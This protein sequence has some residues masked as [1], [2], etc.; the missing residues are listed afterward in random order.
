[1]LKAIRFIVNPFQEN[2]YVL[3]DEKT[4]E[5]AI[6]DPGCYD[7]EEI[8]NLKG[9]IEENKLKPKKILLTHGHFD[10]ICGVQ[11]IT[12]AYG[13]PIYA[14]SEATIMIA[15]SPIHALAFGITIPSP[16]KIDVDIHDGDEVI[17]GNS[18]LLVGHLPGHSRGSVYFYAK[19]NKFVV[20][21]DILFK[22]SIG[23]TDL[24]GGDLQYL[25]SGIKSK[26]LK[27]PEETQVFPGH[28]PDTTIGMEKKTNPFLEDLMY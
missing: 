3:I 20:V 8:N 16:P 6:V 19:E 4:G 13:I 7:T 9:Y 22:G 25:L 23:R 1:M 28:G 5:C 14:H 18:K 24:Q 17:I 21:G 11:F 10:H 15:D 26:L 27:M 2:T 12:K